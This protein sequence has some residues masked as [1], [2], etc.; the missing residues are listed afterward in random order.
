MVVYIL[1]SDTLSR[2]YSGQTADIKDRLVRHNQGREKSTKNGRLWRLIWHAEVPD[3][4]EAM[5]LELRIKKRG[6]RRFLED[7]ER[8][9]QLSS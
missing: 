1:Y 4:S 2:Y 5:K 6:A 3:R 8:R 9:D 7:L